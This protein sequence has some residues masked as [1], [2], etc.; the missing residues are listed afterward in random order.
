[1]RIVKQ[2]P[3]LKRIFVFLEGGYLLYQD[4]HFHLLEIEIQC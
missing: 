3:L 1:M 2:A 4:R